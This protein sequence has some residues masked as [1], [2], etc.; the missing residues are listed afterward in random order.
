M[1]LLT[2][3]HYEDLYNLL[4][5]D[6]NPKTASNNHAKAPHKIAER[7]RNWGADVSVLEFKTN[8]YT[9]RNVWVPPPNLN[10]PFVLMLAHHDTVPDCPGVDDNGSGVAVVD[11]LLHWYYTDSKVDKQSLNLAF[12]L[13]D[14]EEG[15]PIMYDL[16]DKMNLENGTNDKW[17]DIYFGGTDLRERFFSYMNDNNPELNWF[18]GTRDFVETL[19]KQQLFEKISVVFNFETVGYTSNEQKSVPGIPLFPEKGDFIAIVLNE[20][21]QNWHDKF[22]KSNN[23]FP[24]IP[25]VVPDRGNPMPDT[26]RSDHSVFWDFDIPAMMFTDT[27]N[28]RNPH[29]HLPSDTEVN[30]EFMSSLVSLVIDIVQD[31]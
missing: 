19:R 23:P 20:Q 2:K 21:A 11:R 7:W 15:D 4:G 30:F 28:F 29:Y 31:K 6:R 5:G 8:G 27:A 10:E 25:L 26:R 12:V 24:R 9:G 13:P 17:S 22:L 18:A 14:F 3:K 16:L 1:D